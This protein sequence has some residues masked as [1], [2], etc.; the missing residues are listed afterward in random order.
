MD[1]TEF[2][3]HLRTL[4]LSEAEISPAV[5]I[6]QR[7]DEF[8]RQGNRRP[9]AEA[10]W[11]FSRLLIEEGNNTEANYRALIRYCRFAR[12]DEMFIAFLEL[13]DGGEVG[14]NL[15]RMVG[16]RFGV[17][18]RDEVFAG[19]GIPP[20][21]TPSPDKPALLQPIIERIRARLGDMECGEF[22]SACLRDLPDEHFVTERD[23]LEQAGSIDAYL[24][25]RKQRFVDQ[26]EEC[27][28][29]GKLF[30]AQEI[31]PEVL[32]YVRLDPEMG[33]GRRDGNIVYE[34]KIPYMTR[35]YLAE[36]DPVMRRYYACHCPWAR[37]AIKN[38]DVPL[39]ATFCNCSG[40]FHKKPL[41]AAFG[42]S[43]RVDVLESAL[44]GDERCRFAIHLPESVPGAG[45]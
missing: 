20:Y 45:H 41:E 32:D 25:R 35:Q 22:L 40:G 42:Q 11:A 44:K 12:Q 21:G 10:A 37:D 3:R 17:R 36:K 30:F 43:L 2:H 15:F 18:F 14:A 38:G 39:S 1:T 28:R 27:W 6:A 4:K 33:G 19:F 31:T 13:V 7:F 16:E 26:L 34:T 9:N 24:V 23:M 29:E 5:S 8:L